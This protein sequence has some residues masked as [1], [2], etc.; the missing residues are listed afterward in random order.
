MISQAKGGLD[1]WWIAISSW[2]VVAR[3]CFD[4]LSTNG[5][6]KVHHEQPIKARSAPF[7]STVHPEL[8]EACP[9]PVEGG[10]LL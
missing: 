1:E 8:V 7:L 10:G 5:H 4:A 2:F 9:E 6:L 3:S